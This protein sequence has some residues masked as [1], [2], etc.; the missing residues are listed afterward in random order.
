MNI[1]PETSI[2]NQEQQIQEDNT[3]LA[4]IQ[5]ALEEIEKLKTPSSEEEKEIENT[6]E[7]KEEPEETQEATEEEVEAPK[8]KDK[9]LWKEIKRKYQVMAEK[10]ALVKE[11]AKL[12]QML[13]ESLS[14]GTYHYGKSAHAELERA[15]ENK[16]RAIEE[17]N[18]D[19]LI[20]ADLALTKAMNAINDLEKWAYNGNTKKPENPTP[21][22]NNLDYGETE[23][24]IIADWL[25]D[26]PYLQPTSSK[27]NAGLANQV[28]DFVN[29]LD[30]QIARSGQKEAYFSEEYF[31]AIDN[32]I[33]ELKKGAG[34][35]AKTAEQAAH[36]GGVRNSYGSSPTNKSNASKQMI[37]TADEK[38]MC[39]NSGISE[40][41]WLK[42]KLEDLKKGK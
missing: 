39:A 8:K 27:Y 21:V 17:G 19:G 1:S 22:N 6:E 3:G 24:E 34:K 14:S 18:V 15:K 25:D 40:E 9:K 13:E 42:Y 12:R 23:T 26:H 41:E 33:T 4:E 31:G 5:A 10:E 30:N 28:A 35:A 7:E 37:L 20:E 32:Y 2:D 16:K 38:R 36:V 29:R 11:N